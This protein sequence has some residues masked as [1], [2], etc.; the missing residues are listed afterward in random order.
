MD[1]NSLIKKTESLQRILLSFSF[2]FLSISLL[3][4]Y[5]TPIDGYELSL[6]KSTPWIVW[7][8]ILFC[9]SIGLFTIISQKYILN[10]EGNFWMIGF[11]EIIFAKLL[12]L[13]I[14]YIRGYYSWRADNISHLGSVV[15][16]L[17][18]GSITTSDFYPITHIYISEITLLT[19]CHI[20]NTVNYSTIIISIYYIFCMYLL[21]S[22]TLYSKRTHIMSAVVAGIVSFNSY[23][24][25]L[26]PNGWSILYLPIVF[27][28]YFKVHPKNK[29]SANYS[30]LLLISL[31]FYP[32]FHPLSSLIIMFLLLII[33]IAQTVVQLSSITKLKE[34][35]VTTHLKSHFLNIII[36]EFIIFISWLLSFRTFHMNLRRIFRDI[37]SGSS[38]DV[39]QGMS[40][41]LNKIDVTGFDFIILLIKMMGDDIIFLLFSIC[42]FIILIKNRAL[43]K[44][45]MN[46]ILILT[47]MFS[48]GLFYS[49]YLFNVV[50]GLKNIGSSRLLAYL[51]LFA[52]LSA[53]FVLDYILKRKYKIFPNLCIMLILLSSFISV[54]SLY[55]S[56]Y[57][58]RPNNM[59]TK[60]DVYG[61]KWVI[62]S[63]NESVN[64]AY[65]MT[66]LF[67]FGDAIIGN[68]NSRL[69]FSKYDPG[70]PDHFNYS[71]NVNLG[72]S[73]SENIYFEI[74]Q[75]DRLAYT[76]VWQTV[77]RFNDADFMKL[78]TDTSVYKLYNNGESQIFNT[79]NFN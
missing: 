53:S 9:D 74:T 31:I 25:Y 48:I 67:R 49:L 21:A 76:T 77:G 63:T 15:D 70:I 24:R 30:V 8:T 23:H 33:G 79:I 54:F 3:L 38:P 58:I 14:P 7:F 51:I 47:M 72:T 69:I 28:L 50:P 66:P 12:L 32:F 68:H 45:N 36:V 61:T 22:V 55:D 26:M 17:S 41:T 39:I 27:Y 5:Y 44:R 64:S 71:N 10:S 11:L 78:E 46:L 42:A 16:I 20:L 13:I 52:P 62:D 57:I 43:L 37:A 29:L 56:P 60:M 73:F 65:I 35:P 40:N 34:E 2:M 1:V 19:G 75:F 59:V 18:T 4:C 6:Y